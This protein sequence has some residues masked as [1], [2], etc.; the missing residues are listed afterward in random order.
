MKRR[1]RHRHRWLYR[2]QAV[3]TCTCGRREVWTLI[4]TDPNGQPF[5]FSKSLRRE[6]AALAAAQQSETVDD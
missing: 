6:R 5:A 2:A 1:L 3:R 4:I